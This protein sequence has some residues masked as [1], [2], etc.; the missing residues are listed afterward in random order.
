MHVKRFSTIAECEAELARLRQICI[1]CPG[2]S[3][4]SFGGNVHFEA[5]E[6]IEIAAKKIFSQ[7]DPVYH[8]GELTDT[9]P[10]PGVSVEAWEV[11]GRL[12]ADIST[13]T[14]IQFLVFVSMLRGEALPSIAYRIA[15]GHGTK[16]IR[17]TTSTNEVVSEWDEVERARPEIIA[18]LR[19]V[20]VLTPPDGPANGE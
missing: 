3:L 7:I 10:A 6:D 20:G 17:L 19:A 2:P 4:N 14:D 15:H 16:G 12:L 18:V 9:R 13:L 5:F 8:P 1:D 11:L